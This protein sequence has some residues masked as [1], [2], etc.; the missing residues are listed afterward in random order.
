[1]K[2]SKK[3]FGSN[4]SYI[5]ATF[6]AVFLI[7]TIFKVFFPQSEFYINRVV[8]LEPEANSLDSDY[9]V[10]YLGN[11]QIT[12]YTTVVTTLFQFGKSKHSSG[13]YDVWSTTMIK[14]LGAPIVAFIDFNWEKKFLERA[15]EFNLTGNTVIYY[16]L[17][18]LNSFDTGT[19]YIGFSSIFLVYV[20]T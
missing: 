20:Y 9:K 13:D 17:F 4:K 16:L 8:V 6:F 10:V 2:S 15:K 3:L 11:Q 18:D 19:P 12:S 7:L 5:T 1:M 14:S